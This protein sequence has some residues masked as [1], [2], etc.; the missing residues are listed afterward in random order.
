MR[1]LLGT[2]LLIPVLAAGALS[3]CGN[4]TGDTDGAD[5]SIEDSSTPTDTPTTDSPT[6]DTP[7]D[8]GS[9]ADV[10]EIVSETA[11]GG[12]TGD[13]A[14]RVD[15]PAGL[16]RLTRDFRTP[17][18]TDK[19]SSVVERIRLAE[20]QGLYG[21]VIAVGCDVPPS[22]SVEVTDGE[23][24]ITAGKIVKP[25]PECF[26]PVT[27]VAIAVVDLPLG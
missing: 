19:I 8:P 17:L 13:A 4:D 14:V 7:T 6:T 26:A 27:S 18:L 10:V 24:V 23:V 12:Q 2:L 5:S 9:G 21:A 25:M 15:R 11:A 22:A 1:R 20:G 16:A 3:A